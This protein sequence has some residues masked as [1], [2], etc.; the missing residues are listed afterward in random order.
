MRACVWEGRLQ[1]ERPLGPGCHRDSAGMW[2]PSFG[3]LAIWPSVRVPPPHF[4][5]PENANGSMS[6]SRRGAA[7]EPR[8]A[9]TCGPLGSRAGGLG[10]ASGR[11]ARDRGCHRVDRPQGRE[12]EM[13]SP[14]THTNWSYPAGLAK[15]V[16]D[17][18]PRQLQLSCQRK[19]N[20]VPSGRARALGAV[21]LASRMAASLSPMRVVD[22]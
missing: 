3:N 4:P 13:P 21:G 11:R 10:A 2:M 17:H 20:P 16:A 14:S 12:S 22:V 6:V 1:P 15:Y 19:K 7:A 9:T 8:S 5:N 18:G